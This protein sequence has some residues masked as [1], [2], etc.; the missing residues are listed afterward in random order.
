M[1]PYPPPSP[2]PLH[3]PLSLSLV[4]RQPPLPSP[5]PSPPPLRQQ[6][7]LEYFQYLLEQMARCEH[8]NSERLDLASQPPTKAAFTFSYEDRVQVQCVCG[9][10]G[11]G[12]NPRLAMAPLLP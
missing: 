9:G 2:P 12:N 10:G 6:D 1:G 3:P 7:A 11:E 8:A 4:L 5:P